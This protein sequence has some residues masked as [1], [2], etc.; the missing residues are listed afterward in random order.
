LSPSFLVDTDWII[1]F[2]NGNKRVVEKL[3]SLNEEGLGISIISLAELYEGIYYSTDPMGN[4]DGLNDFLTGVTVLGIEEEICRVF[5]KERGKLRKQ[6]R[7][8]GD[9][10]L[11]IASTCLYYNLSLLTNN[12]RHY[13]MVEGLNILSFP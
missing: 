12:R 2:L 4:E 11:L 5:G 10:D 1:H 6:K 9:I 7:L 3:R 8:I 13:E